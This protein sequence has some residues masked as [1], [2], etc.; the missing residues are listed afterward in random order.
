MKNR[1]VKNNYYTLSSKV[2]YH[3]PFF[4]KF[5][6]DQ[7]VIYHIGIFLLHS[8]DFF[9]LSNNAFLSLAVLSLKLFVP[10]GL[11]PIFS[12][13]LCRHNLTVYLH[14]IIHNFLGCFY[15]LGVPLSVAISSDT[16]IL[17]LETDS[18]VSAVS[19]LSLF[20][21]LLHRLF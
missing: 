4:S 5:T 3:I 10:S 1:L 18:N 21:F 11:N 7:F 19:A 20:H 2:L 6:F 14:T 15:P 12:I 9:S 17:S 13:F 8:V 16:F